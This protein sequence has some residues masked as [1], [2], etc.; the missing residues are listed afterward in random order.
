[1]KT[2]F[3]PYCGKPVHEEAVIPPT[4][5]CPADI[6]VLWFCD[7]C[8]WVSDWPGMPKLPGELGKLGAPIGDP[9]KAKRTI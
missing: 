2:V 8:K 7:G 9:A 3:C 6:W 4:A 5:T 1:M